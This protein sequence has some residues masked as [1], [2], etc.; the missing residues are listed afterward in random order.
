[1]ARAPAP[2]QPE[3]F[4]AGLFDV[5]FTA[6]TGYSGATERLI[7]SRSSSPSGADTG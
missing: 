1:M 5:V 6:T 2:A 3:G 7:R 4:K